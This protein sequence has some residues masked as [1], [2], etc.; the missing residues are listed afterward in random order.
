MAYKSNISPGQSASLVLALKK[1]SGAINYDG[2]YSCQVYFELKNGKRLRFGYNDEDG[3][4]FVDQYEG[5]GIINQTTGK[6]KYI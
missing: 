3:K 5:L 6:T 2:D 4:L 1:L